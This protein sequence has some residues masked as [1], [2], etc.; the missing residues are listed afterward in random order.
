MKFERIVLRAILGQTSQEKKKKN[1]EEHDNSLG[2]TIY[3]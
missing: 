1:I 3:I 2:E